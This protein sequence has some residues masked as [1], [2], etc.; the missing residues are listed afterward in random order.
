MTFWRAFIIQPIKPFDMKRLIIFLLLP[1]IGLGQAS[2]SGLGPFKLS[3]TTSRD[4]EKIMT[5]Q[6]QNFEGEPQEDSA[7][8]VFKSDLFDI[9]ILKITNVKLRF[10]HDTLY[11]IDCNCSK[12]LHEALELKYG[13]ASITSTTKIIHC[14]SG[15]KIDYSERENS[16]TYHY[17][18]RA[19]WIIAERVVG[20]YF[21]E[22]C[23]KR[24]ID[25]LQ[26]YNKVLTERVYKRELQ[27]KSVEDLRRRGS[28]KKK[29]DVL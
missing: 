27:R 18:V 21:N 3:K 4:L 8:Y 7:D 26:I 22:K 2:F 11:S 13:K 17:Q 20:V 10:F 15:L 29:L 19:G 24:P 1:S 12:E 9:G 14:R 25:A 16:L 6:H 5:D 23:E 28:L